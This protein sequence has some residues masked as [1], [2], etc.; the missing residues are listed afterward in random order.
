MV[1]KIVIRTLLIAA[2]LVTAHTIKPFS[3]GNIALQVLG[4]ARSLSFA[5]PETAAERIE[6]AYY[7]AQT[8]GKGLFDD[9]MAPLWTKQN[10]L[11]SEFVAFANAIELNDDAEI[12]DVKSSDP[13]RK[14]SQKRPV[15]RIK[16]DETRDE[17]SGCSRNNEVSQLPEAHAIKAVALTPPSSVM[18][19][20]KHLITALVSRSNR[21]PAL[22]NFRV[23]WVLIGTPASLTSSSCREADPI[24][25][26]F[27]EA[28]I[29]FTTGP[30]EEEQF[31]AE[32]NEMMSLTP[33]VAMPECIRIP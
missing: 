31:S 23:D 10:L 33:T 16:R 7:L 15:K 6:H 26:E 4:S 19:Y 18:A 24:K 22:R 17:D 32:P 20:Q 12:K 2:L 3:V 21:L 13:S 11:R 8:Y 1:I 28:P 25:V 29:E 30:E 9:D 5:L 27:V 14:P